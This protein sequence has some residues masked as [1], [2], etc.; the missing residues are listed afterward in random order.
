MIMNFTLPSSTN[1]KR[2]ATTSIFANA[3][4]DNNTPVQPPPKKQIILPKKDLYTAFLWSIERSAQ[5]GVPTRTFAYRTSTAV[6]SKTKNECIEFAGE[7]FYFSAEGTAFY[8]YLDTSDTKVSFGHHLTIL[9]KQDFRGLEWHFTIYT[10]ILCN[11]NAKSHVHWGT[12]MDLDNVEQVAYFQSHTGAEFVKRY[13][14]GS[15]V[16]SQSTECLKLVEKATQ[17]LGFL[18]DKH[19][20]P[21]WEQDHTH[22]GGRRKKTSKR[23][24]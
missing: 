18:I 7:K 15:N 21:L 2:K 6:M 14:I 3:N 8:V 10:P 23:T 22:A 5:K 24:T 4:V 13:S 11:G 16:S 12:Q 20:R 1:K 19:F 9:P 17:L